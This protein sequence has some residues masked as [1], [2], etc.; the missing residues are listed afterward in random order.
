MLL[1]YI[2]QKVTLTE[3]T[4][5][6]MTYQHTSFQDPEVS[7]LVSLPSQNFA[8]PPYYIN[9]CTEL[10]KYKAGIPLPQNGITFIPS[11]VKVGE[12]V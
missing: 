4:T 1:F 10:K 9:D 5:C 11:F 7:N 12:L 2:S 3:I 8:H 6:F